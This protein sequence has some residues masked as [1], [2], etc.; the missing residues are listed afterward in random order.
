M[1][2]AIS[3]MKNGATSTKGKHIDVSYHY[4]HNMVKRM[5][6]KVKLHSFREK[7]N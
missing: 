3:V 2:A 5:E 4:V 6:I 7:D 1:K